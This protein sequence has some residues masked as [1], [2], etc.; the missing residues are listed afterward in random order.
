MSPT[1]VTLSRAISPGRSS[2]RGLQ[3][4][5]PAL[6]RIS[7]ILKYTHIV[8]LKISTSCITCY[9]PRSHSCLLTSVG[10]APGSRPADA[11]WGCCLW[12]RATWPHSLGHSSLSHPSVNFLKVNIFLHIPMLTHVSLVT[13]GV[14]LVL[15]YLVTTQTQSGLDSCLAS[16]V[17]GPGYS[18]QNA[19]NCKYS[20]QHE[21]EIKWRFNVKYYWQLDC[22]RSAAKKTESLFDVNA[23]RI[24]I[25]QIQMMWIPY[26]IVTIQVLTKKIELHFRLFQ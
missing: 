8:T 15:L 7:W 1:L 24:I 20:L 3:P 11:D 10:S 12:W 13:T 5:S 23:A 18:V 17:Q 21:I 19:A 22:K 26:C 16:A 14:S 6:H 9:W 2:W 25:F 4:W